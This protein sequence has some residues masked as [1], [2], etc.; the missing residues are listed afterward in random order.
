ML[1]INILP[2]AFWLTLDPLLLN[3]RMLRQLT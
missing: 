3:F 1:L 2:P